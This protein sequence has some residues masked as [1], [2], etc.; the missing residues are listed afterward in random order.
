[1]SFIW[2]RG[3]WSGIIFTTRSMHGLDWKGIRDR[4]L[5]LVDRVSDRDELNDVIAQMVSELSALHIFVH[6]GDS[7]KPA[8][9]VEIATL[10]AVLAAG[11]RRRAALWCSTST[12]TILI[13]RMRR[14]RWRGL[15]RWCAKAKSSSSIDG[16]GLAECAGRAGV[17][18]R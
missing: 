4:Y 1:M 2:M 11:M 6:G 13:C 9:D 10:G 8:D 16:T 17:A 5:P 3:G 15:T 18:P 12:C 14:H 7:R